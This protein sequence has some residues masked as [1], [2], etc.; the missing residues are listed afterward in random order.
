MISNLIFDPNIHILLTLWYK[1]LKLVSIYLKILYTQHTFP[2]YLG[3][4]AGI[5]FDS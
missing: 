1:D 2:S 4:I 3:V 5:K